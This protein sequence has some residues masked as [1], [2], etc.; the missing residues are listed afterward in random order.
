MLKYFV[1]LSLAL[2]ATSALAAPIDDSISKCNA[3]DANVCAELAKSY[4]FG[5]NGVD[6][7]FLKSF[8]Y[9]DKACNLN[10][11]ESCYSLGYYYSTGSDVPQDNKKSISLLCKSL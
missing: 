9:H 10:L 5:M 7:D 3:G 2:A 1:T 6:E 8:E 4:Y 11:K